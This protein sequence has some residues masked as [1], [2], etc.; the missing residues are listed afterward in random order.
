MLSHQV[1]LEDGVNSKDR[2]PLS[3]SIVLA[4]GKHP[5]DEEDDEREHA[6]KSV[7]K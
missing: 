2:S 5:Q 3:Q 4:A 6:A 1:K 7:M